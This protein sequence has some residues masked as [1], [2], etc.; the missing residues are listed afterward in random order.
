MIARTPPLN[1]HRALVSA[2]VAIFI[3]SVCAATPPLGLPEQAAES[4]G[5][6]PTRLDRVTNFVR[7]ELAASRYAGAMWLV[8]RDGKVA[9]HGAAG[10]R[11]LEQRIPMTEDTVVRIYS[12]T[13]VIT[14]ATVLSLLEEGRFNLD[15]GVGRYL[16]ALEKMK[17][18]TGGTAD[19]PALAPARRAVTI[20]HLLTHTS[21]L[22]YDLFGSNQKLRDLYLRENLWKSA[23]LDEFVAK[24]GRLPL[25]HQPGE[26]WSYGIN[27]DV[28]GALIEAVTK[29]P[30]ETVMRERIFEP[31]RMTSTR[32]RPSTAD[33]AKLAHVYERGTDGVLRAQLPFGIDFSDVAAGLTS[34]GG[35]LISTLHDYTRFAQMLLNGG[36]LDGVRV[37][38]RKTVELMTRNHI[39]H[40][41]PRPAGAPSGFGLG[42]YV[43]QEA[44][45]SAG[46]L[47]S[48]GQF[49]WGGAASTFVNIDPRERLVVLLLLQHIPYN[50]DGVYEK[51]SNTVYQALAR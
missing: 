48:P 15:E 16:P 20:R 44:G 51:F 40:L 28:L 22:I 4:A 43:A 24:V 6:A 33:Q 9:A 14:S 31:L 21:G 35:G 49:G 12:M 5:F 7:Q 23:S 18:F 1:R 19:A 46:G 3:V 36:E 32:F 42:V 13:K 45:D 10:F 29:Q 17:V 38:G 34:G 8:A 47:F 37:L 30:L 39:G 27:T 41:T 11:D 50:E 2:C 25:A 26:S